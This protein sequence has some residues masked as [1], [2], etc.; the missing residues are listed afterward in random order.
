MADF[1]GFL[2][3]QKKI[4]S[5]RK[6]SALFAA[7][8]FFYA[9]LFITLTSIPGQS[10]ESWAYSLSDTM[11]FFVAT[12]SILLGLVTTTQA[13]IFFNYR[14]TL[15]EAK[16]GG[17]ALG[18]F[19]TG[20]IATACCSPVVAGALTIAGFAGAGAFIL[21]Y[22][23]Q[24]AVVTTLVLLVSLYYSTKIVFCEECRVKTRA[25]KT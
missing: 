17:G 1:M 20:V 22:E 23:L 21:K 6:H 16:A 24:T 14:F 2:Q 7:S 25:S 9:W 13:Y 19:A 8:A 18:A 10:L 12:T 5:E 15:R 11:K 3:A 4:L